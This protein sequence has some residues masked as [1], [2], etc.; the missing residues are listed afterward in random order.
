MIL[1]R[2]TPRKLSSWRHNVPRKNIRQ[3][4]RFTMDLDLETRKALEEI[5]RRS[6]TVRTTAAV[7]S[8]LAVRYLD[9]LVRQS[10]AEERGQRLALC[11]VTTGCAPE[12]ITELDL[13]L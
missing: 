7:I 3:Y 1:L 9:M 4:R 12:L 11:R 5:E 13:R 6:R 10:E 2:Y 8:N